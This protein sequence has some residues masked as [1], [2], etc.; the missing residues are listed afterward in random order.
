MRTSLISLALLLV[1]L[2]NVY[3]QIGTSYEI[4]G[5]TIKGSLAKGA[6][7]YF[8]VNVST[9]GIGG[10]DFVVFGLNS[11]AGDADLWVNTVGGYPTSASCEGCIGPSITNQGKGF[12]DTKI[13]FRSDVK[14]PSDNVFY[15]AIPAPF[16]MSNYSFTSWASSGKF[17][18]DLATTLIIL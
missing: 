9:W 3:A 1:L 14:W 15:I 10:N 5:V 11:F 16:R 2:S 7:N 17:I 18:D 8:Y 12:G 4:P 13:I 6:I